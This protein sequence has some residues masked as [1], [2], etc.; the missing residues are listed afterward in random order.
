MAPGKARIQIF[1]INRATA[2][3]WE[4]DILCLFIKLHKDPSNNT[5]KGIEYF[6]VCNNLC[7]IITECGHTY[8][9]VITRENQFITIDPKIKEIFIEIGTPTDIWNIIRDYYECQYPA[10]EYMYPHSWRP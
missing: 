10:K 6:F 4:K 2:T 7:A 3:E 5:G 1:R 9:Y 8:R